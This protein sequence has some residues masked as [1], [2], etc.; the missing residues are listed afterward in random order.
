[1]Q[2]SN[3]DVHLQ[4]IIEDGVTGPDGEPINIKDK[5]DP[6]INQRGHPVLTVD[7]ETNSSVISLSQEVFFNPSGQDPGTPSEWK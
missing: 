1:M 4:Q 2:K 6:W 7:R 5:M 3:C